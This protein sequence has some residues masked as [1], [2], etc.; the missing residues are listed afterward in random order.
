LLAY[1]TLSET[2]F[3]LKPGATAFTPN[4][5][6]D[7]ADYL[8]NKLSIIKIYESEF[9]AFPFPRSEEA[10]VAQAR[11][12]GIQCNSHAAEAFMLLKEIL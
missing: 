10:I 4:T 5:W 9:K 7:I 6:V 1:E 12:R 11:I 8:D 3:N 2:D